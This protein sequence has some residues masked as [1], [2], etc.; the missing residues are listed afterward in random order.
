LI[1]GISGSKRVHRDLRCAQK[2]LDKS[3][4]HS[5]P[6]IVK[7]NH[8]RVCLVRTFELYK[9]RDEKCNLE[10][11]FNIILNERRD[12]KMYRARDKIDGKILGM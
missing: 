1:W 9:I 11:N 4:E 12:L 2:I 3:I 10:T 8:V 5:N 7:S 6:T